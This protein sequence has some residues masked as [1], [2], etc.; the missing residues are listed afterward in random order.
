MVVVNNETAPNTAEKMSQLPNQWKNWVIKQL[1]NGADPNRIAK[2]LREGGFTDA[3]IIRAIP[4]LPKTF[5]GSQNQQF[6]QS[7]SEPS[8]LKSPHA[9]LKIL[10]SE[11]AQVYRL[12]NFL[13]KTECNKII[14]LAK[15]NLRPSQIAAKNKKDFKGFRTSTTCDLPYLKK[16]ATDNL[17]R[18]IIKCLGVGVGEDEVIQAQHYAV[19]QEFKAHTDY[20]EPGSEEFKTYCSIGGQRT[21]TFMVYLN[22]ACEG[23]ET[24]F[25]KL[26]IS[27]KPKTGTAIIWNNLTKDG[28]I[29][30]NTQHQAHP[31]ISGEKVI[32]TKWFRVRNMRRQEGS[33]PIDL[34]RKLKKR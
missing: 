23:G 11:R 24:E 8:L 10:E 7:L 25:P 2:Q 27:I 15:T 32:I 22:D 33:R 1:M 17:E 19:G 26:A 5:M 3:Q 9:G 6:F 29:N 34:Y 28:D 14:A 13:T 18:K 20:F 30:E 21:W 12:D 31:V 16:S 4:S